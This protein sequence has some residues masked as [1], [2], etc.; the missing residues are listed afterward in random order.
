MLFKTKYHGPTN[1]S[2]SRIKVTSLRGRIGGLVYSFHT[3]DD[4]YS[5]A[6]NHAMAVDAHLRKI[7]I[8][9]IGD[10]LYGRIACGDHYLWLV[11]EYIER[12]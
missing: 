8:T 3:Y 12:V 4:T 5:S 9:D 2:G 1:Y 10:L 6:A 11:G 7:R